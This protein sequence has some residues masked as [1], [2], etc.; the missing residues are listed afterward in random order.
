MKKTLLM[1]AG[2]LVLGASSLTSCGGSKADIR[3]WCASEDVAFVKNVIDNFKT[4]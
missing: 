2:A 4:D 3:V 1:M